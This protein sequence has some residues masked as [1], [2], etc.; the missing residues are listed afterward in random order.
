M[1]RLYSLSTRFKGILSV[2]VLRALTMA[3][4]SPIFALY[5]KQFVNS[6]FIV[7]IIYTV[8]YLFS[9]FATIYGSVIIEKLQKRKTMVVGLLLYTVVIL[10][11]SFSQNSSSAVLLFVLYTFLFSL[12]FFGISLYIDH[13]STNKNLATHFG[14]NGTLTNISWIVGPMLGGF[15]AELLSFKEVFLIASLFAFIALLVFIFSQPP[16]RKHL[17]HHH[18]YIFKNIRSFFSDA[19]MRRSYFHGLGFVIF[20]GALAL[21]PLFFKDLGASVSQIGLFLGFSAI[22]WIALELPIGKWADKTHKELKLFSY[23]YLLLVPALIL[24]G[25]STSYYTA[26]IFL[27]IT[28]VATALSETTTLSHFYRHV[29]KNDIANSSVFLTYLSLGLFLGTLYTTIALS[30]TNLGMTYVVLGFLLIPF[31]INSYR[32][33]S[34][35]PKLR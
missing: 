24:F 1:Q 5:I 16:E 21:T 19:F 2:S 30:Q 13:L 11:L 15:I 23:T 20:Y 10:L 8:S 12:L 32:L 28:S 17:H 14:E 18:V 33:K 35:T 6:E 29:P 27:L 3:I 9:L 25:F 4:L 7:S 26:C 22:P 31:L 34:V